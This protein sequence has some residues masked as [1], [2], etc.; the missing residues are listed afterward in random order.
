MVVQRK[1]KLLPAGR[2]WG[3]FHGEDGLYSRSWKMNKL[4][5]P[6]DKRY[7]QIESHTQ[8]YGAKKA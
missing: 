2:T 5:I 4:C 1:E 6:G 7:W 8:K 3:E